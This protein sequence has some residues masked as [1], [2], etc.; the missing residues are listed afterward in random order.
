M[1]PS[2]MNPIAIVIEVV[3][4]KVPGKARLARQHT[5]P[6]PRINAG[7]RVEKRR[8]CGQPRLHLGIRPLIQ[9]ERHPASNVL[10][11]FEQSGVR[12]LRRERGTQID[13]VHCAKHL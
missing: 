1:A 5:P 8:G 6:R 10:K 9:L 11:R 7:I 4:E 12:V 13:D 3:S 2:P